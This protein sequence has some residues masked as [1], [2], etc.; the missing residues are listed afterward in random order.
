MCTVLQP[1][2]WTT[3]SQ[4]R[5]R[6]REEGGKEGKGKKKKERESKKT[7]QNTQRKKKPWL[8][9][10]LPTSVVSLLPLWWT[11]VTKM[12]SLNVNSGRDVTTGYTIMCIIAS[13]VA[14][15]LVCILVILCNNCSEYRS[16]FN[17]ALCFLAQ[18]YIVY[19]PPQFGVHKNMWPCV[20]C[21][22][23]KSE[24][25]DSPWKCLLDSLLT[26]TCAKGSFSY[27]FR[28][29]CCLRAT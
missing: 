19:F 27:H 10:N 7:K 22:R 11:Q 24:I 6:G 25:G 17:I 28:H 23:R 4:K 13:S 14:D 15:S 3:D 5:K 20:I 18:L 16:Y 8:K 9:L 1:A 29:F 2:S 26:Q 12:M 21:F